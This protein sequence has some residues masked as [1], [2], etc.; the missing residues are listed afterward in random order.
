M[1]GDGNGMGGMQG[2]W[3]GVG[4]GLGGVCGEVVNGGG[5]VGGCEPSPPH[6]P[7]PHGAQPLQPLRVLM[8]TAGTAWHAPSNQTRLSLCQHVGLMVL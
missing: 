6:I 5:F 2:L 8:D 3:K 1:V 7:S 4:M